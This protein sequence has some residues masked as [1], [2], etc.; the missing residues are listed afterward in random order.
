MALA[1]KEEEKHGVH[2]SLPD[3]AEF[4]VA[5][6]LV[7]V[8]FGDAFRKMVAEAGGP[9]ADED[10]G[11][12]LF[13]VRAFRQEKEEGGEADADRPEGIYR[14]EVPDF[15]T[16]CPGCGEDEEVCK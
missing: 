3:L 16:E 8:V 12:D 7:G 13:R 11:C 14:G 9:C 10:G 2:L 15:Y 1:E 4:V 6:V 5:G